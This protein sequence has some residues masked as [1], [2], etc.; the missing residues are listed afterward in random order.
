MGSDCFVPFRGI[1][2]HLQEACSMVL[3]VMSINTW[4]PLCFLLRRWHVQ[5][6]NITFWKYQIVGVIQH[7]LF[8]IFMCCICFIVCISKI[9][10][11]FWCLKIIFFMLISLFSV[12]VLKSSSARDV[13][14]VALLC[15][16]YFF[17]LHWRYLFTEYL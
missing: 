16:V 4:V 11:M 6:P 10:C 15:V 17:L 1:W 8:E 9:T 2:Y 13:L 14:L 5:C 7:A 12:G 3:C